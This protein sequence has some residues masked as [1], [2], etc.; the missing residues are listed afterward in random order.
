[1]LPP[2]RCFTCNKLL[3]H[4]YDQVVEAPD[5]KQKVEELGVR[6][7]CCKRMLLTSVDLTVSLSMYSTVD[8]SMPDDEQSQLKVTS[9]Q[10][11]RVAM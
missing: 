8:A 1:M 7:Y 2:P 5:K 11:R 10:A 4:L 9:T 6:R 3:C